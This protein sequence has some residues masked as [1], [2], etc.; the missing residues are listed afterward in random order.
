MA[1]C[2]TGDKEKPD[3][4]SNAHVDENDYQEISAANNALG[5]QLINT[6]DVEESENIFISPTSL[7]MALS[8]IYNGA[9]GTTKEEISNVL[10]AENIDL[11][12]WNQLNAALFSTLQQ[13]DEQIQLQIANSIWLNDDYHFEQ[14][15]AQNTSDYYAAQQEEINFQSV[16]AAERIN[17][18]VEEATN[19]KITDMVEEPFSDDLVAILINAIYFKGEWKH[20]FDESKTEE[21]E[22]HLHDGSTKEVPLMSLEADLQ[23]FE[24]SD[25]QTVMLPYG[26]DG[27]MNMHVFLPKENDDLQHF[28]EALTNE[29]WEDWISQFQEEK[30]T[31]LLPKFELEY[32]AILDETLQQLGMESAF[33]PNASDFSSIIEENDPLW[34]D[35]VMQ[36]TFIEVNEE[37]TEGAA[38][39]SIEVVTES[40]IIGD[41]PFYMEVNRPFFFTITDD[42]TGTILFIGEIRNPQ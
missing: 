19:N 14:D 11:E 41:E 35:Q 6:I 37:G 27:Q 4:S 38:A 15:F 32:E 34:I 1:G 28:R 23:Y 42:V 2:G 24:N 21:R 5:F 9:E 10:Q 18:W 8:M 3:V 22:F 12:A 20:G 30:G 25:F 39:T 29:A 13:E 40:E 31:I 16:N 33:N 7:S 17:N 26:E 36:K